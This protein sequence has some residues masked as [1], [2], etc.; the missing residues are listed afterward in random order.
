MPN[1][2]QT[3]VQLAGQ[4]AADITKK[5]EN[6]TA[7]LGTASKLYRYQFPDQLLIHAQRP[8]A[9]ACAE[10]DLWNK[11]MR[12]YI[13]RGSKG[14][15]LVQVNNGRSSLHYVFDIADTGKR[16]DARE[17]F[18]WHYRNECSEAITKHLEE[19]FNVKN[20]N[21]IIGLFGLVAVK[22]AREFWEKHGD[23]VVSSTEGSCLENL[24]AHNIREKFCN[25]LAY[26]VCYMVLIR[27]G[28][29]SEKIL[30]QEVFDDILN[31]NTSNM[32]KILGYAVSQIGELILHQIA[33][34]VFQYEREQK[35]TQ[36]NG[37]TAEKHIQTQN[38][39]RTSDA[40]REPEQAHEP[41]VAGDV[42]NGNSTLADVPQPATED[43]YSEDNT[44]PDN[45]ADAESLQDNTLTDVQQPATEGN[46]TPNVPEAALTETSTECEHSE[47]STQSGI[48]LP[49]A[50]PE[51]E[52]QKLPAAE[53]YVITDDK[54][55][56]GGPKA[57]F[58]QNIAAISVLKQIE[59]ENRAA[60][61]DEQ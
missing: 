40:D 26:S 53:N 45:V 18:L 42:R 27:C 59:A 32:T 44:T 24:D 22:C 47:A 13:R 33:I 46:P 7:F 43:T 56:E 15:G 52:T 9:T 20:Q 37:R 35:E 57:K 1:K 16:R 60:T 29:D 38:R 31:F 19:Y 48:Q 21:G 10:F 39:Q 61:P 51:P 4:T 17:I 25:I 8:Q 12:R 49:I 6:W 58:K 14:I 23:D 55:G 3:Y 41:P 36:H 54:L 11:R 34:A 50:V 2:L 28:T 30:S 5:R